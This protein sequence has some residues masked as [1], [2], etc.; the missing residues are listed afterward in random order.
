MPPRSG[1]RHA[2]PSITLNVYT[3]LWEAEE[4]RTAAMMEAALGDVP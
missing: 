4:D 1:C 2:K 3:H